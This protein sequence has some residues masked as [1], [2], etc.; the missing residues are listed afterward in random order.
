MVVTRVRLGSTPRPRE[1]ASVVREV[2]TYDHWVV[3]TAK[4]APATGAGVA[5]VAGPDPCPPCPQ[6]AARAINARRG[7]AFLLI[8][9]E[10]GK[11]ARARNVPAA[12]A[13]PVR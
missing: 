4:V 12:P 7:N 11:V 5:T 6:A 1:E 9:L 3:P 2:S 10:T 13:I 8:P